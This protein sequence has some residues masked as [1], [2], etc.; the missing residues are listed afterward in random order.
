MALAEVRDAALEAAEEVS[1]SVDGT[2]SRPLVGPFQ[3]TLHGH[4]DHLR[5]LAA[6]GGRLVVQPFEEVFGMRTVI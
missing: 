5:P 2:T 4:V 3:E 6:E 1:H